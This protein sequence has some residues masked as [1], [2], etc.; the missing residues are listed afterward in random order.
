[1]ATHD[2][3]EMILTLREAIDR[4]HPG[5]PETSEALAEALAVF[6]QCDDVSQAPVL[7]ALLS[8]QHPILHHAA[9]LGLL[10][11][12][13]EAL[14]ALDLALCDPEFQSEV[15]DRV[16]QVMYFMSTRWAFERIGEVLGYAR[17]W[18][19]IGQ[20]IDFGVQDDYAMDTGASV[21]LT[22]R[23]E[24]RV[25]A[26][27][28]A[29]D[30]MQQDFNASVDYGILGIMA[31]FAPD[32]GALSILEDTLVRWEDEANGAAL[33]NRGLWAL[34][35]WPSDD[36][37]PILLRF[38]DSP[39]HATASIALT[40]LGSVCVPAVVELIVAWRHDLE[41]TSH[42]ADAVRVLTRMTDDT[43]T[44]ALLSLFD[45]SDILI[46]HMTWYALAS[47][48]EAVALLIEQAKHGDE[49]DQPEALEA[50]SRCPQQE[51]YDYLLEKHKEVE[52]AGDAFEQS[53]LL[54]LLNRWQEAFTQDD[55]QGA[56]E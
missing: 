4:E 36:A 46:R 26:L 38:L 55:V 44:R 14:D 53:E 29:Q 1:M 6:V 9:M 28:I 15:V 48:G 24:I 37:L 40:E 45:E 25:D 21:I 54:M 20:W 10:G 16:A 22:L 56:V 33:M 18:S 30:L 34:T 2:I 47:R 42:R 49:L 52:A 7:V 39:H 51:A 8:E 17:A 23:E 35:R 27:R 32:A 12:G 50:L 19:L 31:G 5:H 11:I 43:T 3:Q 41:R 13:S